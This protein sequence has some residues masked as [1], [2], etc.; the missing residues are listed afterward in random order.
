[1]RVM[2]DPDNILLVN[3]EERVNIEKYYVPNVY[4]TVLP[5]V[6][7]LVHFQPDPENQNFKNRI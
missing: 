7:D 3:L 5:R 6:A 4:H 2:G 1:M